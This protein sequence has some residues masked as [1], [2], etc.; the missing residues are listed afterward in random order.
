LVLP[1]KQ[2]FTHYN[3]QFLLTGSRWLLNFK[4]DCPAAELPNR[5][6]AKF[7]INHKLNIM[8]S[9]FKSLET[10]NKRAII[11]AGVI[12]PLIA[13][14][15]MT[16]FDDEWIPVTIII[17][18]PVYWI[19]VFA[20][21]WIYDGFGSNENQKGDKRFQDKNDLIRFLIKK[22]VQQNSEL[23]MNDNKIDSLDGMMLAGM[24]EGTIVAIVELYAK[25]KGTGTPDKEIFEQFEAMRPGS[26]EMPSPL[27]L[28]SYISYRLRLE[29]EDGMGLTDEF[30]SESIKIC[31]NHYMLK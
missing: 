28:N 25:L 17:C 16:E 12:L 3:K 22:R 21:L 8:I 23:N 2:V 13:G 4:V 19:L 29:H 30:I 11:V 1:L 15:I 27:N 10:G 26:G 14:G 24:P 7:I 18:L 9:T 5:Y 6:T 31:S 20:G